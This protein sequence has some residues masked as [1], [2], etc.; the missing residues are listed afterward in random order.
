[1]KPCT[2]CAKPVDPVQNYCSWDCHVA[3]A[4]ANG[5]Q[6]YTPNG[7]PIMCIRHDGLMTECGHGDHPDYKFPVEVTGPNE[8]PEC[9]SYPQ[10]HA[11]IYSDGSVALT[12]YEC[13]YAIWSLHYGGE[14][15]GGNAQR[16][17]AHLTQASIDEI[18]RRCPGKPVRAL[19]KKLAPCEVAKGVCDGSCDGLAPIY[20]EDE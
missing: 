16:E 18:L 17:G 1:M 5:G 6:V 15:L 12:M 11:L 3:H 20:D 13:G 9:P 8:D 14:W 7:L 2:R 19:R 10:H 4:K